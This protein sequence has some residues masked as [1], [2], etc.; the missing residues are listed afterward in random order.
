MSVLLGESACVSLE[1]S[2]LLIAEE[3]RR[4]ESD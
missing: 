4:D 1:S 3:R 2:A